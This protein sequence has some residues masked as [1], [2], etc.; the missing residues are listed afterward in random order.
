MFCMQYVINWNYLVLSLAFLTL[1]SYAQS[2]Y[3]PP[4]NEVE[5][6]KLDTDPNKRQIL[7]DFIR[8]CE[9]NQWK[10]TKALFYCENTRMNKVKPVRP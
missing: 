3:P 5:Q 7:A 1:S 9:R 10:T 4:C 8:D 2:G 6:V